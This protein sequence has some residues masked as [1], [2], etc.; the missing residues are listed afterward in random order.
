MCQACEAPDNPPAEDAWVLPQQ[1]AQCVADVMIA[2][3]KT[4]NRGQGA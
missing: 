4:R 2:A 1:T 3:G